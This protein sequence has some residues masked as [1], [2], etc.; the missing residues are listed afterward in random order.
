MTIETLYQTIRANPNSQAPQLK[1]W[2]KLRGMEIHDFL[3]KLQQEGK[4]TY[5]KKRGWNVI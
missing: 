3:G 5:D 4:I 2:A 1:D